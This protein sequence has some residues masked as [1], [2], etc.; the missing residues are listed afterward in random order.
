[1]T[2]YADTLRHSELSG[3]EETL[4]AVRMATEAFHGPR[5]SIRRLEEMRARTEVLNYAVPPTAA[6][7]REVV[8]KA[9][10][11]G[12]LGNNI[13]QEA[14]ISA[15]SEIEP[16]ILSPSSSVTQQLNEV[17]EVLSPVMTGEQFAEMQ[18]LL[19]VYDKKEIAR[20]RDLMEGVSPILSDYPTSSRSTTSTETATTP[21]VSP[22][23]ETTSFEGDAVISPL[24]L[25]P[26][27][28]WIAKVKIRYILK[29][30]N[31]N[32]FRIAIAAVIAYLA[33]KLL[34]YD[35]TLYLG[36]AALTFAGMIE[37]LILFY[38]FDDR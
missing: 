10:L 18:K 27:F 8:D 3:F 11:S 32:R 12:T 19:P 29:D 31:D 37:R 28:F 20:I 21:S 17:S 30:E 7:M 15:L 4:D 35:P 33:V 14:A 22:V 34:E 38:L 6:E 24:D 16:A 26:T 9:T 36:A 13:Q 23:E 1:M 2:I 25:A 5:E